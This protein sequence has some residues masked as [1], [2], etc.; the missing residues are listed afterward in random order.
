MN[1]LG[2]YLLV[3]L[4]FVFGAM[5][6]FAAALFYK[7]KLEGHYNSHKGLDSEECC[8][9][10]DSKK[11]IRRPVSAKKVSVTKISDNGPWKST[12]ERITVI[13]QRKDTLQMQ[14]IVAVT[15]KIDV[16]AFALFNISYAIFNLIYIIVVLSV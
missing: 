6:E 12:E 15:T 2:Y 1:A 8:E 11:K 5:V 7:Q 4:L 16:T 14:K 9:D 10:K 3:S 13:D